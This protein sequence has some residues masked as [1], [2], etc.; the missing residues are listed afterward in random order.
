MRLLKGG[1]AA[2]QF[3]VPPCPGRELLVLLAASAVGGRKLLVEGAASQPQPLR[4]CESA[5][6]SIRYADLEC[7]FCR[8]T[9]RG[10]KR[11]VDGNRT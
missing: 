1:W 3:Q 10:L 11:W 5:G 8:S 2:R 7:P 9:P 6:R 4:R